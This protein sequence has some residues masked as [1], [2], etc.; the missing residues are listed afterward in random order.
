M[1]P[2]I[3]VIWWPYHLWGVPRR[4][5]PSN[6]RLEKGL[7]Y[8]GHGD[9]SSDL[10]RIT[11]GFTKNRIPGLASIPVLPVLEVASWIVSSDKTKYQERWYRGWKKSCAW[12]W[13]WWWRWRWRWRWWWCRCPTNV[14]LS[15]F[16]IVKKQC[17]HIPYCLMVSISIFVGQIELFA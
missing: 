5:F 1:T 10:Q 6:S 14:P 13:W 17:G 9:V 2:S 3:Q 12:W 16:C 11:V 4:F 8:L 15:W 7:C